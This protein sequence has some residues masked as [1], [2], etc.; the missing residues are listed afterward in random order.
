M[1]D[2]A[3]GAAVSAHLDSRAIGTACDCAGVAEAGGSAEL[4]GG[5]PSGGVY[6]EGAGGSWAD[7]RAVSAWWGEVIKSCALWPSDL[8]GLATWLTAYV[9]RV[10]WQVPGHYFHVHAEG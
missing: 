2:E 3:S 10:L 4:V 5:A 7:E 8:D 6:F 1:S 9:Y